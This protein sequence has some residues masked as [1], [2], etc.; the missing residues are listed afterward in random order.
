MDLFLNYPATL[1][2]F[3]KI[4]WFWNDEIIRW[5]K[6]T[7]QTSW[8]QSDTWK[9][10]KV[11][12]KRKSPRIFKT[13]S[14]MIKSQFLANVE[15]WHCTTKMF[16]NHVSISSVPSWLVGNKL[17]WSCQ[18]VISIISFVNWWL[19]ITEMQCSSTISPNNQ[20]YLKIFPSLVW[21]Y[22]RTIFLCRG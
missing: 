6:S 20:T 21:I 7:F 22:V 19:I 12:Q 4:V 10:W 11:F 17:V 1:E 8:N 9:F 16:S 15:K 3:V 5:K 14:K 13:L 18:R 2:H